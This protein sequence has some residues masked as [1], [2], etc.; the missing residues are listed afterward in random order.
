MQI[1]GAPV[2]TLERPRPAGSGDAPAFLGAQLLPGRGMMT[3]QIRAHLPGR[4]T[5]DLLAAPPLDRAQ[6]ILDGEGGD[7]PG[8]P[9]YYFGAAVLLPFANRIHGRPAPDGKSIE[10][11]ILGRAFH[12][13]A[14]AGG[15]QPGVARCA[16]HGL[17]LAARVEDLRRETTEEQDALHA[18]FPAGDFAGHWPSSTEISFAT[19]LRSTSFTFSVTARNAGQETLPLG[20]GWHPYFALPSGRRSQARLHVPA[21][22][23]LLV[24]DYDAVVPTG[25]TAAVA[26]TPYD[27]SPPGGA[28][29]GSLFLDDCFVDL[30]RSPDGCVVTEIHDPEAGYGLRVTTDS[31]GLQAV[32]V[33]APV[34][35]GFI[36]LEPQ[37]N[38]IDPFGAQWGPEVDT[39]MAL[40]APEETAR[41]AVRL[42]LL[43]S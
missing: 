27:F 12:L 20:I 22:R 14:N 21:R 1:G 39:G 29:L 34:D 9:S 13:P 10:A 4:G 43:S 24:N 7:F 17:L 30:V 25:E 18:T 32:Q 42:E 28:P 2:V 36:A 16:M 26:G 35:S 38:W 19:I 40:L 37:T 3:L 23:R 31:P 41:Y 33:Y 15:S 6:E 8:N 5:T 11:E